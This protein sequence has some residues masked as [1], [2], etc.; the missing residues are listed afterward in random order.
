MCISGHCVH[1]SDLLCP[2][3]SIVLPVAL[4]IILVI[5]LG[6]GVRCLRSQLM[7]LTIEERSNQSEENKGTKAH[8]FR[9]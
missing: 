3:H 1:P 9:G 8:P 6:L 2:F 5:S 7:K 4:A